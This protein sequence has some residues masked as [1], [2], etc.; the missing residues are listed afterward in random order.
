MS[1]LDRH[2]TE[3]LTD[4]AHLAQSIGDILSTP[5]GTRVMRREYGSDL[6]L[7]ID[8]PINPETMIDLFHATAV[9]LDR[10]EPR[11]QLRRVEIVEARSGFVDLR[12]T[13][14]VR[15]AGEA[16]IVTTVG[17]QQ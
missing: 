8:A 17:A 5:I 3:L 12:L 4:D 6:P 2:T 13:G 11:F 15:N 10:W 7:L 9:A 1:G 14:D 16:Q